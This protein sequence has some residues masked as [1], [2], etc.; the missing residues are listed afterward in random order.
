MNPT[1]TAGTNNMNLYGIIFTTLDTTTGNRPYT[2]FFDSIAGD[3]TNIGLNITNKNYNQLSGNLT[4]SGLPPE[5]PTASSM[6]VCWDGGHM[7]VNETG[8]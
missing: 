3:G 4:L 1:V 2:A 7:F 8:C 6:Y 5:P